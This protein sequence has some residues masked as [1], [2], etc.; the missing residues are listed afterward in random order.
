MTLVKKSNERGFVKTIVI[1]VVALLVISY[2]GLNLRQIISS[3]TTQDNFGYVWSQI[4]RVWDMVKGSVSDK[5]E[6][7]QTNSQGTTTTP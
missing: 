4:V 1:I 5:A 2:F 7:S 3:P 6:Q